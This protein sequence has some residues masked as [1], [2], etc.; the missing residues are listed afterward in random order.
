MQRGFMLASLNYICR[1]CLKCLDVGIAVLVRELVAE[2]L[3]VV[4]PL[5]EAW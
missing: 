4:V 3:G 1:Y 5:V 2:T